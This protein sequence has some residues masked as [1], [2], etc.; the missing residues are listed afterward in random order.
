VAAQVAGAGS[1][2]AQVVGG[3]VDVPP[4]SDAPPGMESVKRGLQA[5]AGMFHARVLLHINTSKDDVTEPVSLAPDLHY[6]VTDSFQVGLLHNG[7]MGLLTRPG[8]GLCLTGSGE[9]NCPKVY[10][11]F[12]LDTLWGLAFG[13]VHFSFRSSLYFFRAPDPMHI[14]LTAG[15]VSKLHFGENVALLIEPQLG[16]ALNE[17][18]GTNDD[19]LFLPME[20]QFQIV[21]PLVFKVL[22]GVTGVLS[23]LGDTYQI[24]LGV[25]FVTNISESMDIG[26]RF[27]FDNLLGNQGPE[28]TPSRTAASSLAVILNL[29]F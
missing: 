10:N 24:P 5:P 25:A 11:N 20:L 17:R 3:G 29:R 12:G 9:G 21:D 2:L 22:S 27:S 18:D 13:D 26:L 15:L 19:R 6:A 16:F 7:P 14:L 23:D 28:P 4:V 8:H 1:A